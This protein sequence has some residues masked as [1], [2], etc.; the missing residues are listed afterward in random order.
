MLQQNKNCLE[1]ASGLWN[2]RPIKVLITERANNLYEWLWINF[3]FI[4]NHILHLRDFQ[5]D[6]IG[7]TNTLIVDLSTNRGRG[8][9]AYIQRGLFPG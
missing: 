8:P 1:Y 3:G 7:S 9:W 5:T 2:N 4:F 6:Y